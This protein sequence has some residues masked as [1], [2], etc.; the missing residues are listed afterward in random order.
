MRPWHG[1]RCGVT[2]RIAHPRASVREDDRAEVFLDDR[3]VARLAPGISG[4]VH[5]SAGAQ[6]LTVRSTGFSDRADVSLIETGR[7]QLLGV[8]LMYTKRRMLFY[9]TRKT[10]GDRDHRVPNRVS[11]FFTHRECSCDELVGITSRVE[12]TDAAH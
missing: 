1:A 7:D 3:L 11:N 4:D 2:I 9:R 8:V 10:S 5:G 6:Q 12:P